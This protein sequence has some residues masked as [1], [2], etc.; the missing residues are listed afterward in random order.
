MPP[1]K[2]L[3]DRFWRFVQK[4]DGCWAWTGAI[5]KQ[6]GYGRIGFDAGRTRGAHRVSYQL[7]VG[8]IPDG[9]HVCHHCDNR[10]C[11]RPDHLFVGTAKDNIRDA[12]RKGR[13]GPR[14]GPRLANINCADAD[15]GVS[16]RPKCQSVKYATKYCSRACAARNNGK[17]FI[18]NTYAKD[19]ARQRKEGKAHGGNS[20]G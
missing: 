15:C 12:S 3:P 11:V 9:L 4:G 14:R 13:M 20:N 1:F 2:P 6:T 7:N 17:N 18:G 16:F 5:D 8:P 19:L 10:K